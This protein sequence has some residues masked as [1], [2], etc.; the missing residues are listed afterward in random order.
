[1]II[2]AA[3]L[4]HLPAGSVKGR[5]SAL[6]KRNEVFIISSA[7]ASACWGNASRVQLKMAAAL[8]K[9]VK[10]SAG[11]VAASVEWAAPI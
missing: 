6:H 5:A 10:R 2:A 11:L 7:A 3:Q 4:Q 1:M 8:E 9:D